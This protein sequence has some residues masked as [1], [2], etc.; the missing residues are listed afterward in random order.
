MG[1]LCN[2]NSRLSAA[3]PPGVGVDSVILD[4]DVVPLV[5]TDAAVGAIADLVVVDVD[6][7]TRPGHDPTANKLL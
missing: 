6:V 1:G 5:N 2:D 7:V 4:G 3:A